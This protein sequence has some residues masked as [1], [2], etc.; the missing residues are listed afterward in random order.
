MQARVLAALAAILFLLVGCSSGGGLGARQEDSSGVAGEPNPVAPQPDVAAT[1][2]QRQIAR[3]GELTL[4]VDDPAAAAQQLRQTAAEFGGFVTSEYVVLPTAG[5][6]ELT[7]SRSQVTLS[8]P[9]D[10]FEE[11]MDE[12]AKAGTEVSRAVSSADITTQV[13]DVEARI[14]TLRESIARLEDLMT[15]AGS[16]EEITTLEAE[17]TRRQAD[18]ES[19]VAQQEALRDQVTQ[20]PITVTLV[21]SAQAKV[22]ARGGFVAGLAAGWSAFLLFLRVLVTAVGAALPFLLATA[23]VGVPVLWLWRRRRA[24]RMTRPVTAPE[25]PREQETAAPRSDDQP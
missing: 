10:R 5:E 1:T 8:V 6:T 11:A 21:T 3:S 2:L 22:E 16:L 13:V 12:A 7:R 17:L 14:R 15:R 19:L 25:A 23:L 24:R 18:L 20:S 4:S 9:A